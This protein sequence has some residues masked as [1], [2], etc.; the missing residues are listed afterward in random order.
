MKPGGSPRRGA[1]GMVTV[2]LAIGFLTILLV[3]ACLVGVSLLGVA[4]AAVA[5]SSAQIARQTARGDE[6]AVRE[7]RHRIPA[8][9]VVEIARDASG[10]RATVQLPIQVPLLGGF[11]VTADAWA[12]YEPGVGP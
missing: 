3:T 11:Q 6:A 7:A 2:E 5:E 9:A 10:V 12:A 1:R 8:G 4:Q